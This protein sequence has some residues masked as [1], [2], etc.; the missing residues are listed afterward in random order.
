MTILLLSGW[1]T[2]GKDMVASLLKEQ[3]G[4]QRYAF[5]DILKEI[6]AG[7][8]LFPVE[9]AHSEAGK[10]KIPLMGGGKTVRELLIFRGQKIREEYNDPGLF[11]RLVAE[12]IQQNSANAVITD[13]RLP[14]ELDTLETILQPKCL[15]KIR[16]QRNGLFSS[17]VED[18]LTETQLDSFSFDFTVK[19]PGTTRD[20]LFQNIQY[21]LIPFIESHSA[22]K[23]ILLPQNIMVNI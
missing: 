5:A 21:H 6:V 14:I 9:W 13:W 4:F 22:E 7:E 16:I 19:N 1:S 8:Y 2:S 3:Y 17:P 15:L 10:L 12:K 11:A 20:A 18:M 23:L